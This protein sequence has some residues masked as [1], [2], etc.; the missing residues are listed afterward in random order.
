MTADAAMDRGAARRAEQNPVGRR[1]VVGE[2][3]RIEADPVRR[4]DLDDPF[5][6]DQCPK[7][8]ASCLEDEGRLGRPQARHGSG[9]HRD[10]HERKDHAGSQRSR[11]AARRCVEGVRLMKCCSSRG[12]AT[13]VIRVYRRWRSAQT[14]QT[15]PRWPG[16]R[17]PRSIVQ[18]GRSY[19]SVTEAANAASR[20]ARTRE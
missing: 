6:R 15:V 8:R 13:R 12:V 16:G 11:P 3:E 1:I 7:M 17:R 20:K 10:R 2:T 14:P 19:L 5:S 9:P 4:P 18:R